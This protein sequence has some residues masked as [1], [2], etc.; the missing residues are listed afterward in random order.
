MDGL[1][2]SGG[3]DAT[4][5][6]VQTNSDGHTRAG[7]FHRLAFQPTFDGKVEAARD[8]VLVDDHIGLGSTLTFGATSRASAAP[9]SW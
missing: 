5:A 8:H 9:S 6:I 2:R 7:G 1:T 3:L 4:L